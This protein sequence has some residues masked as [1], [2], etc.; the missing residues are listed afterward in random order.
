M[1]IYPTI[2]TDKYGTE[3]AIISNDGDS[4]QTCLRGIEFSGS[5]FDDLSP[6]TDGNVEKLKQFTFNQD[7]LCS[8]RIA[9]QI[10]ILMS[11]NGIE[12]SGELLLEVILGDPAK[13]G[14]IDR[15]DVRI[16]LAF[17]QFRYNGRGTSGWFEDELLDIQK[18]LP[19]G[20]FMKA[21]INCA[22][23]D[24]SPY[25]HGSFGCMKCFRNLKAEYLK[26][27]SKSDFWAVHDLNE[28]YVQETFLC[29]EFKRRV[30]GT[31]YRG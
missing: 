1:S 29:P 31:G 12:K 3:K 9:C 24:Y 15:E 28:R 18:Q 30:P 16:I 20:V 7:C 19:A 11:D 23:S 17:K 26:V 25:G 14:G 6:S 10:P 13:N 5:E 21:C 22:Y 2:Y 27:K 8:C 4:L